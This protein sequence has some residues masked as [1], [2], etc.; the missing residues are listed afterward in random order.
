MIV[1]GAAPVGG[2]GVQATMERA[3]GSASAANLLS[4]PRMAVWSASIWS[5]KSAPAY[6][7]AIR[8]IL[9]ADLIVAGPG[10]LYTS[11]LPNLLVA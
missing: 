8:A 9:E 1:A 10:S 3:R 11:V 7:E 6:P 5:L 2:N 4:P